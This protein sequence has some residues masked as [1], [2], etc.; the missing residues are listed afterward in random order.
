MDKNDINYISSKRVKHITAD[1]QPIDS[2]L[3]VWMVLWNHSTWLLHRHY[4][5]QQN[6][7]L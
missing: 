3:R 6:K 1:S 4:L 2:V 7:H 5:L